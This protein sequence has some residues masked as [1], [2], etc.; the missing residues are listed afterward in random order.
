[1]FAGTTNPTSTT[2]CKGWF[3]GIANAPTSNASTTAGKAV[4]MQNLLASVYK[5]VFNNWHDYM[6]AKNENNEEL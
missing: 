3:T 6:S 4:E 2:H 1:M 5:L